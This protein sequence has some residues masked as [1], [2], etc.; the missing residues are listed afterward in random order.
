MLVSTY[1]DY[2]GE[3]TGRDMRKR[4]LNT[5]HS[6]GWILRTNFREKDNS[7]NKLSPLLEWTHSYMVKRLEGC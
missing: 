4:A 1:Q 7:K 6:K 3:V 2:P 5:V